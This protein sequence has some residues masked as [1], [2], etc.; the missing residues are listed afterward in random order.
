MVAIGQATAPELRAFDLL[1]SWTC[2]S[3][4]RDARQLLLSPILTLF[5]L[6]RSREVLYR[7]TDYESQ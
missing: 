1:V 4:V 7:R 3:L 6:V 5:F 2:A